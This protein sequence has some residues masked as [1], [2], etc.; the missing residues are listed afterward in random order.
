MNEI[1]LL[2]IAREITS[3]FQGRVAASDDRDRVPLEKGSVTHSTVRHPATGVFGLARNSELDRRPP[4]RDDDGRSVIHFIELGPYLELPVFLSLNRVDR[5]GDDVGSE[6]LRVIRHLLRQVST[7]N[8]LETGVVLDEFRIEQ[9]ASGQASFDDQG[10]QHA[11]TGIH[12]RTQSRRPTP[13]DD[14]VVIVFFV[15]FIR[16]DDLCCR[17]RSLDR[18]CDR[19]FLVPIDPPTVSVLH[20]QRHPLQVSSRRE[21]VRALGSV[22]SRSPLASGATVRGPRAIPPGHGAPRCSGDGPASPG[23]RANR[24]HLI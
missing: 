21:V 4:R 9:L 15:F 7:Q 2:R 19:I 10:I 6:L 3:L 13:Y 12:R 22:N 14:D 5:I 20:L 18:R 8:A 11:P 17:Y 16:H 24:I 23:R 1:H